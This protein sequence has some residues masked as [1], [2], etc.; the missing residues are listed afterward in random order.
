MFALEQVRLV[1]GI[2][3][4]TGVLIGW[5]ARGAARFL[6]RAGAMIAVL[7]AIG[8]LGAP[9]I[10]ELLKESTIDVGKCADS[11]PVSAWTTG[12]GTHLWVCPDGDKG[13]ALQWRGRLADGLTD[14]PPRELQL[15]FGEGG[16]SGE[17]K[18]SKG[19]LEVRVS[20]GSLTIGQPGATAPVAAI[21]LQ[22]DP[23]S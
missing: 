16:W 2:G 11:R 6:V 3:L 7:V 22:T 1:G 23:V 4:V 15:A 13:F 10:R 20:N 17:Y 19:V 8:V 21:K 12:S 14:E 9:S 18:G 5:T